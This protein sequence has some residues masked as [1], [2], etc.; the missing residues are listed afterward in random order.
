MITLATPLRRERSNH[1]P[2]QQV[3]SRVSPVFKAEKLKQ[4]HDDDSNKVMASTCV[5]VARIYSHYVV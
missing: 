1:R 5:F 4:G 2:V 3:E